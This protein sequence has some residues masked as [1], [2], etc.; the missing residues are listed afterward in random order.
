MRFKVH[1]YEFNVDR[2]SND[3]CI[4]QYRCDYRGDLLAVL[5]IYPDVWDLCL[6]TAQ[7]FWKDDYH[8]KITEIKITGSNKSAT[9]KIMVLDHILNL[10][11]GNAF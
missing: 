3:F 7:K 2:E 1:E 4:S 8:K 5:A 11:G 6:Y 10:I 9:V